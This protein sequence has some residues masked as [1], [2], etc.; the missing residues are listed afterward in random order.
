MTQEVTTKQCIVCDTKIS[1]TGGFQLNNAL[2]FHASGTFGSQFDMLEGIVGESGRSQ[3]QLQVVICDECIIAKAQER[4]IEV[5]VTK[6]TTTH[7]TKPFVLPPEL[8][9]RG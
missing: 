3:V 7:S 1:E 9:F 8:T 6:T 2:Y 5:T 4:F